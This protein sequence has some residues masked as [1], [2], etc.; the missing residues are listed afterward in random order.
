LPHDDELRPLPSPVPTQTIFA[1]PCLS[2]SAV[3]PAVSASAHPGH[4]GGASQTARLPMEA[5]ACS[6]KTGL[7]VVPLLVVFQTPPVP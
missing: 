5:V 7:N 4:S 3:S 1:L 6:S 2:R